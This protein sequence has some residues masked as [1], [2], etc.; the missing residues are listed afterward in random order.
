M[1]NKDS[2]QVQNSALSAFDNLT[3]LGITGVTVGTKYLIDYFKPKTVVERDSPKE[4]LSRRQS[5]EQ[6][7][8]PSPTQQSPEQNMFPILTVTRQKAESVIERGRE[9]ISRT[10]DGFRQI[11]EESIALP[12]AFSGVV[13]ESFDRI[14]TAFNGDNY[15]QRL[16]NFSTSLPSAFAE[17]NEPQSNDN[18]S[19]S[20]TGATPAQETNTDLFPQANGPNKTTFQEQS[21]SI[22]PG[23]N[24]MDSSDE[25]GFFD[26]RSGEYPP[27]SQESASN[28]YADDTPSNVQFLYSVHPVRGSSAKMDNKDAA[29]ISSLLS[30][31][32]GDR[33]ENGAGLI[34]R[35]G[36]EILFQVDENGIVQKSAFEER[37]GLM[38]DPRMMKA[39]GLQNLK[40][41]SEY[42]I[43]T[44]AN[45][46]EVLRESGNSKGL[47]TDPIDRSTEKLASAPQ[48]D[49]NVQNNQP[50]KILTAMY[51]DVLQPSLTKLDSGT[52]SVAINDRLNLVVTPTQDGFALDASRSGESKPTRIGQY[53]PTTGMVAS[54]SFASDPALQT[55]MREAL[56]ERGINIESPMRTVARQG[57]DS[58]SSQEAITVDPPSN[59][60][61]AI[62]VDPW[63]GEQEQEEME[64]D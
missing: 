27:I 2:E 4:Q 64:V 47:S 6:S 26:N 48:P 21:S 41:Y 52:G 36:K 39:Y 43:N 50:A 20:I 30:S 8:S 24:Q 11:R 45:D 59:E 58:A 29:A 37:P 38:S 17:G 61:Q 15:A 44:N 60:E 34:I 63:V 14:K 56:S 33:V 28:I 19:E 55:Q 5:Q 22:F 18:S 12:S 10:A 9:D 1:S 53:S 51:N 13:A 49:Q 23:K 40:Q 42:L 35:S 25:L 16:N 31:K 57:I 32:T 62:T 46:T 3:K 7:T 54:P